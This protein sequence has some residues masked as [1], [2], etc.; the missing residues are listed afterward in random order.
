MFKLERER[1]FWWP[2]RVQVPVDNKHETQEF[3][4]RIRQVGRPQFRALA[5]TLIGEPDEGRLAES[6]ASVIVD[7]DQLQG[8]DGKPVP[9][10]VERLKALLEIPYVPRA[11][12]TAV[13]EAL[14]PAALEQR[15]R[16]N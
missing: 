15:R 6:L 11:I 14:A 4:V 9:F 13:L 8:E 12:E 7:W 5:R 16:G 10:S 1:E 3:R 2:V